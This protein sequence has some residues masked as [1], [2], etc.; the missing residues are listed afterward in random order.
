M[1][2]AFLSRKGPFTVREENSH[3]VVDAS[4]VF[5]DGSNANKLEDIVNQAKDASI[6]TMTPSTLMHYND[7]KDVKSHFQMGTWTICRTF[8]TRYG[9]K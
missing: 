2:G 1:D 9:Q 4:T 8:L 7:V 3:L 5:G 6:L